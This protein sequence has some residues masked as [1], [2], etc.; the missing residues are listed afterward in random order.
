MGLSEI[1]RNYVVTECE[2]CRQYVKGTKKRP[3]N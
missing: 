2:S 3:K 1:K